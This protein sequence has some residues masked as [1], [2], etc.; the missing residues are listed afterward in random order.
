MSPAGKQ[1]RATLGMLMMLGAYLLFA[2]T[3][4]SV[5]WQVVAGMGAIQIAF[6]RYGVQLALS[7]LVAPGRARFTAPMNRR[8]AA[9]LGLRAVLLVTATV[10]NFIALRH[11][12]L[13]VVSAI[14]FSAPFIVAALAVPILGERIGPWRWSAIALGFVGMLCVV[15]PFGEEFHWA[16]LISVYC[17]FALALFSI[18]TRALSG[19]VSTKMM[20]ASAGLAG[21][22][23]L[24]PF[25]LLA[26][27]PVGGATEW[28]L[29]LG[30]GA[31]AWAG[32][33]IFARAHLYAEASLLM[34]LAYSYLIYMTLAGRIMFG[35]VPDAMTL[36]GAAI[37]VVSGLV[38]WMRENRAGKTA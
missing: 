20:Q 4:S 29:F 1:D 34:P 5:K 23:V 14:M 35:T 10:G 9:L 27:Q 8:Q 26:W 36:L 7:M 12:S 28:L 11:L 33:E 17:A 2:L 19:E 31:T 24:M 22:V 3:D 30:V 38:I 18:V 15:R 6:A 16:T 37:I 25:A 13:T 32:H 21:T